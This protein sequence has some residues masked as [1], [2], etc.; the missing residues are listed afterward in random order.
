MLFK[1]ICSKLSSHA[2][3]L[4]NDLDPI[5][6]NDRLNQIAYGTN[7]DNGWINHQFIIPFIWVICT[8]TIGL[9]GIDGH[10]SWDRIEFKWERIASHVVFP[11]T[12]WEQ[13]DYTVILRFQTYNSATCNQTNSPESVSYLQVQNVS[14]EQYHWYPHVISLGYQLYS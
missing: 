2:Y 11:K 12:I 6:N 5:Q 10:G 4:L 7:Y 9:L 3:Y 13:V 14:K 8:V 1:I